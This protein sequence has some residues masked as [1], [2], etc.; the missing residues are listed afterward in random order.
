EPALLAALA[1][2]AGCAAEFLRGEGT[3]GGL[4][5][6]LEKCLAHGGLPPAHHEEL[7]AWRAVVDWLLVKDKVQARKTMTRN[8]G[9]PPAS[10]DRGRA[11]AEVTEMLAELAQR[12]DLL[13]TLHRCGL[14]DG[15]G[16]PA[17]PA[18]CRRAAVDGLRGSQCRGF[19]TAHRIGRRRPW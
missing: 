6:A 14:G 19:R 15:S 13:A 3:A 9:V 17:D 10:V 7:P 2:C 11:K 16:A 5:S 1:R 4:A 12:P 8:E 18:A